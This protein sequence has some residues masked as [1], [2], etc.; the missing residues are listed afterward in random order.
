MHRDLLLTLLEQGCTRRPEV[1]EVACVV[2]QLFA[3]VGRVFCVASRVVSVVAVFQA[4]VV[5][6][7]T[8]VQHG[9]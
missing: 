5:S 3:H 7:T 4:V 2:L 8:V 1:S 9:Q 6:K